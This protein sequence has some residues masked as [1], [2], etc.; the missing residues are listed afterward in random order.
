M[1]KHSS[2]EAALA[3]GELDHHRHRPDIPHTQVHYILRR[4][5]ETAQDGIVVILLIMLLAVMVQMLWN[6]GLMI[7]QPGTTYPALVSQIVFVLILAEL[8]RT[9]VFYLREHRVSVALIVEV[10]IVSTVQDLILKS[11]HEEFEVQR[12]L[13]SAVLLLVLGGLLA[14]ERYFGQLSGASDTSAH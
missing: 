6:L 13:G 4:T 14:S 9:L 1:E 7:A 10:A 2:V 11:A 8:Y 3:Q 12:L 5:L